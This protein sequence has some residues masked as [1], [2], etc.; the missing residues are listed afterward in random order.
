[1]F[2][3]YC[4]QIYTTARCTNAPGARHVL[5]A[6][7]LARVGRVLQER[8]MRSFKINNK[9]LIYDLRARVRPHTRV[10]QCSSMRSGGVNYNWTVKKKNSIV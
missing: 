4:T 7:Q 8:I 9:L 10:I 1:M 5:E 6:I 2:Y 3:V